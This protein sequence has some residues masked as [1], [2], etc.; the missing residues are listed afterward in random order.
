MSD[1]IP[2]S[3]SAV[4]T[5]RA[6]P[7]GALEDLH[8]H[9]ADADDTALVWAIDALLEDRART[10]TDHTDHAADHTDPSHDHDKRDTNDP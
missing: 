5:L 1:H 7:T 4:A 2:V 8:G 6:Y 3:F 10:D 9:A